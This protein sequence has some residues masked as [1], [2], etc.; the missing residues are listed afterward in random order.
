MT[1]PALKIKIETVIHIA[2]KIA[3]IFYIL[4]TIARNIKKGTKIVWHYYCTNYAVVLMMMIPILIFRI[5][6]SKI[7]RDIAAIEKHT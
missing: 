6:Q 5:Q 7:I 3:Y 1:V 2:K 4:I